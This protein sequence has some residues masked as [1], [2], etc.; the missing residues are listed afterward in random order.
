[1]LESIKENK[2]YCTNC[3]IKKYRTY[4]DNVNCLF[5]EDMT[6]HC[7]KKPHYL[8]VLFEEENI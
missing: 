4:L 2:I 7:C 5:N 6:A 3:W 8:W 1:M